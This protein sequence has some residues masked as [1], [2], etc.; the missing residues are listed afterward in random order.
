MSQ[1][2][3]EVKGLGKVY[4]IGHEANK[5]NLGHVTL[6]DTLTQIAKKPFGIFTSSKI[7]QEKFWALKDINLDIQPG[8]VVGLIG[9]NGSGKST[10]LK[11]LS[12]ITEPTEGQIIMRGKA[13]SLLEVGTGFHPELTGREN[14]FFNGAILGM[15][16]SEIREKFDTIVEFSGVEKFLDT[17]VKFYSS[18][19]YVRL[20]FAVAAHLEPDILIVDEVLAVGDAEF[21]KKSL[22]KMRDVA[23]DKSRT[24]IFVSHSMEAIQAIC[25]KCV[26]LSNGEIK[27]YG[28]TRDVIDAYTSFGAEDKT[29]ILE[30][31]DRKGTQNVTCE[32]VTFDNTIAD[33]GKL[34]I[35]L[36]L[37]SKLKHELDD[38]KLSLDIYDQ[39]GVHISNLQNN[40]IGAKIKLKP[41]KNKIKLV[42]DDFALVPGHYTLNTFLAEDQFNSEIYDW[43]EDAASFTV[44]IRDYYEVG[45]PPSFNARITYM[46]YHIEE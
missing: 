19:M 25:N 31:K 42:I 33:D 41:G 34:A 6:R 44:P 28:D 26:W 38:F 3:I 10:F 32:S 29:P 4:K 9:R 13:A 36:V 39:T 11:T 21:Q 7:E 18:G 35:K 1:P 16:Q 8:D 45:I 46:N 30:R 37:T 17:P 40:N 12:R 14:I 43:V 23:A 5:V 20:A 24:V 27:K 15:K 2:V 22:G